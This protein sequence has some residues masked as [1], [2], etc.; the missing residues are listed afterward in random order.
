MVA[1]GPGLRRQSRLAAEA[2]AAWRNHPEHLPAQ[3]KWRSCWFADYRIQVCD[4]VR[5]YSF[6]P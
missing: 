3:A 2:L 4:V 1:R 5:D 6:K